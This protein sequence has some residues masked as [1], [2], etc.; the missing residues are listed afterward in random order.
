MTRRSIAA[1][2]LMG[3]AATAEGQLPPVAEAQRA[4]QARPELVSQ[5]QAKIRTSGLTRDQIRARLRSAGYP[6]TLLDAYYPGVTS[7]TADSVVPGQLWEA[8]STLGIADSTE[9]A[10]IGLIP[11][12]EPAAPPL[13]EQDGLA[14]FGHDVFRRSTSQ[15]EPVLSGPVDSNYRLGPGDVLVL[16]LTGDVEQAHTLEVTRE[17]FVI[18]PQVGQLFVANLSV[19]QLQDLLHARLSRAYSGLR[20]DGSG[21]TRFSVS[22]A[23]VRTVQVFVMGDVAVPGSYQVSSLGTALTS[24]YAAGGPTANGTMRQIEVR[25]SGRTVAQLD[26][27]DYLLRGDASRDA[28]LETGDVVFVGVH[29]PRVRVLGEIVRPAV[30]ELRGGESLADLIRA[31]GGFAP[32]ASLHRIQVRRIVPP[33]QRAPG[34]RDRMVIDIAVDELE[35]GEVPPFALVAGDEVEVFAVADRVRNRI[36]VEGNVWSPGPAGFTAGMRLS[37][38]LR[39]AGGVRPDVYTGQVLI[40][41]LQSDDTRAMLRAALRD[42]T[43]V[44]V[45]DIALQEDDEIRVFSVSEFRP[46]RYVAVTGAVRAP[47]QVP[48]REGMTLRDLVLLAG[49]LEESAFLQHAEVARLPENRDGGMVATTLRVPLDSTFLFDKGPDG[50]YLGPPGLPAPAASA[51]EF[52]LKPYDN[53]LILQQPDWELQRTVSIQGQVRYPGSYALTQKSERLSDLLERAGGL[54]AEAYADG[55]TFYRRSDKVGRVGI[56]LTRVMQSASYRDNLILQAGDSIYVPEFNP[57][58]RVEGAVNSPVGVAF[59]P[60]ASLED[61]IRAAGGPTRTADM[62]RS[63]VRQP[64]GVVEPLRIRALLLPNDVP[65]PR[66]GAVVVVPE[67]MGD[68]GRDYAAMVGGVAQVLASIVA[69]IAIATR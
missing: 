61:Y 53:V 45:N 50:R 24:L 59:M 3:F 15:F 13:A 58:V 11:A 34:G 65:E 7:S 41:R 10:H 17:G 14:L 51:P 2:L 18:V 48:Y 20:R 64:N 43:G 42:S 30:Y 57:I 1:A 46:D 31:A 67:R 66:P 63:Y 6:E 62:R 25:R 29:G 33:A 21:S 52:E 12:A 49:G 8:L 32:T 22:V 47:G 4:L 38:A 9:F 44:P 60:G 35:S 56:D 36:V 19:G 68:Q 40:S 5:L 27:Y 37:D 16:I 55:V 69:I 26:L 23:R 28:R 39:L 54:T